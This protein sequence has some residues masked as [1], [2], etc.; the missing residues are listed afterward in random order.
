MSPS[1]DYEDAQALKKAGWSSPKKM[2]SATEAK[3]QQKNIA[4]WCILG[5]L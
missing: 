2:T 1:I 3:Q 5:Q 4:H